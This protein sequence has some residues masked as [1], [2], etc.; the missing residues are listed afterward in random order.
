MCI[1]LPKIE[2]W[3]LQETIND[4]TSK[5]QN[6]LNIILWESIMYEKITAVWDI[7]MEDFSHYL[8]N[9]IFIFYGTW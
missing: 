2:A 8:L 5:Q 6:D 7:F 4:I 3:F 9:T 1:C